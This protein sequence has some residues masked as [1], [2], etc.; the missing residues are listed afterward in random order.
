M[1]RQQP[2]LAQSRLFEG[3]PER[4]LGLVQIADA[5]DDLPVHGQAL[6]ARHHDRAP[7]MGCDIPADRAKDEGSKGPGTARADNQH[8]GVGSSLREGLRGRPGQQR[9][10]EHHAWLQ[11]RRAVRG[12]VQR[13]QIR[14]VHHIRDGVR[15]ALR[16]VP[17][18]PG[19][20]RRHR[21]DPQ[22]GLPEG[23][24]A[25]RPF[26]RPQRFG[27]PVG[28][29]DDWLESHLSLLGQ[30]PN[31]RRIA[32]AGVLRPRQL[33]DQD[34]RRAPMSASGFRPLPRRPMVLARQP[35]TVGG[36]ITRHCCGSAGSQC[37]HR[38]YGASGP[39]EQGLGVGELP[40]AGHLP[41][42]F[43]EPAGG[44]DLR[45]HGSGGERPGAQFAGGGP[46]DRLGM[47]CAEPVLDGFD[48]PSTS[49]G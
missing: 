5:D 21:H 44:F 30:K 34:H 48:V 23:S 35:G 32:P 40:D 13:T 26:H 9:R 22:G 29:R 10:L 14:L 8:R 28:S 49:S 4:G 36:L 12:A 11:F 18:H 15:P 6:F 45:S 3:E 31:T 7:G 43:H 37:S 20:Q 38:D 1:H 33:P 46:V 41:G 47:W 17:A 19:R 2:R 25:D 39:A 42:R 27:G 24:F 16:L